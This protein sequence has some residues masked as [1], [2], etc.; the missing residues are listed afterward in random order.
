MKKSILIFCEG[1]TDQVLIA[2]CLERFYSINIHRKETKGQ[3]I[4]EMTF[5]G[6]RIEAI[7]GCEK[8]KMPINLDKIKDNS[9]NNGI[10]LV[11]FDA[12]KIGYGN[13]SFPNAAQ[14]LNDIKKK[15]QVNFDFYLWPNNADDGTV[16]KII[17][18]L[19]L[20]EREVVMKCIEAHQECLANTGFDDL[21]RADEKDLIRFYLYT[22]SVD[23]TEGRYV[24]YKDPLL[25]NLDSKVVPDLQIF[26]NF[27]DRY[28]G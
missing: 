21:R 27:L 18:Q 26:K 23:R 4:I 5:D 8:L 7:E 11:I 20:P 13:N 14:S 12:D 3:R 19:V 25:W 6:G 2:D 9:E 15:S 17:R 24:N 1:V 10:N 16:E 22:N 28:F